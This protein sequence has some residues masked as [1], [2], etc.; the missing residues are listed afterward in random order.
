MELELAVALASVAVAVAVAEAL[1]ALLKLPNLSMIFLT[2]V[3]FCAVRF[4]TRAAVLASL[5]SFAAYNFFFI[6]PIYTFTVA[7]PQ[8]LFALLIFLAVA[9]LTGSLTG[10]IRDQREM[11]IGNAE[12]T[13][14]LYD[15]S[16]K[17]SGASRPDDVLWAAAAHLHATFGGRIVLLVAEGDEL[18]IRAAWPPDAQLDAAALGAANWAQQKKE[19][20]GWGTG[21]LPR[22]AYQ[23]RPAARR[24]RGDRGLRLRAPFRGSADQCGGRAGADRHPRS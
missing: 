16:R 20:A 8:E 10:R 15:Y 18:Q 9:V 22:I 14:S 17:L 5:A 11:V 2:A 6:E 21:T 23:F 1:S 24:A 13:Q 19:P 3:L 7:Q 12:V 4:G